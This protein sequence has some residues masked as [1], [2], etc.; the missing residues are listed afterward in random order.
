M[1]QIK[2]TPKDFFLNF[3]AVVCVYATA[4]ALLTLLFEIINKAFPDP[5]MWTDPYSAALRTAIATLI[6]VY[7]LLLVVYWFINKD[8]VQVP[9]KQDLWIRR[10]LTYLTL[11]VA[12]AVIIVD[13]IVLLNQF[14]SGDLSS[15]FI[16]K[17]LAVLLVSG[18]V[19][20]YYVY[21]LR[22]TITQANSFN[23]GFAG[24]VAAVIFGS[25][26]GGFVIIGSPMNA[27]LMRFDDKKINDLSMIQNQIVHFW[28]QKE[29]LPQNL[30]ALNSELG[31]FLVPV[32]PQS[33]EPYDYTVTGPTSFRLC[34]DFNLAS[35][36]SNVRTRYEY[37]M[38][39]PMGDSGFYIWKH[40]EG[41]QC[42]DRTIDPE[43]F[44]PFKGL[45][46]R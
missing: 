39:Y 20:G 3:A 35:D 29:G 33:N 42:F 18:I 22:R 41:N 28:Q 14:L 25:I 4:I 40:G 43:M 31:G 13:L 24:I 10:W 7:P 2:T 37:S 6:I 32:D 1:N 12:G 27:R 11:F 9:E 38:P 36:E 17:V 8:I 46:V 30:T 44:P 21:S 5:L 15:R 16:W 26:V 23:K 45:P 34:A 19:F